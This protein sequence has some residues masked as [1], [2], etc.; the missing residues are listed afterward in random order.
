MIHWHAHRTVTHTHIVVVHIQTQARGG[1]CLLH[2]L[3][4]RPRCY[5]ALGRCRKVT[6]L[7]HALRVQEGHF[8]DVMMLEQEVDRLTG[9][10]R[11]GTTI[12]GARLHEL[13]EYIHAHTA[14]LLSQLTRAWTHDLPHTDATTRKQ[15]HVAAG[16]TAHTHPSHHAHSHIMHTHTAIDAPGSECYRRSAGVC[17]V[18]SSSSLAVCELTMQMHHPL[19]SVS[20][21][22]TDLWQ[23]TP[24]KG[25]HS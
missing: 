5:P 24:H 21:A 17:D 7:H 23:S 18:A 11:Q 22:G 8:D 13:G 9:Q 14:Q 16:N 1:A 2:V 3:C 12:A 25:A 6:G 4:V 15:T 10:H 19:R 20:A